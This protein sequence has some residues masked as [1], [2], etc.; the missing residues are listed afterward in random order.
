MSAPVQ[1]TPRPP[2]RAWLAGVGVVAAGVLGA[3]A[4]SVIGRFNSEDP[5][6]FYFSARQRG[7]APL[8]E[9]FGGYVHVIP[10]L[11]A[12]VATAVPVEWAAVAIRGLVL[13]AW[14]FAA[15]VAARVATEAGGPRL[16]M[17]A[18]LAVVACP[19][20]SESV[21][22]VLAA[23]HFPLLAVV[24]LLLARQA[25]TKQG[26]STAAMLVLVVGLSDPITATLLAPAVVLDRA[27]WL[28]TRR[29]R[30]VIA[31]A[32]VALAVQVPTYLDT[33]GGRHERNP[34]LPWSDMS[35]L[36]LAS[37]LLPPAVAAATVLVLRTRRSGAQA[38]LGWRCAWYTLYLSCVSHVLGGIAD[39]YYVAPSIL[40]VVA[41]IAAMR[42]YGGPRR[43]SVRAAGIALGV[44]YLV[45]AVGAFAPRQFLRDGLAW[46]EAVVAA[47]AE[48]SRDGVVTVRID[49]VGGAIDAAPC[50]LFED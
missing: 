5:E 27:A 32:L 28:G 10:R 7:L 35:R 12:W 24:A 14:V 38:R 1:A 18:A 36:W 16:G 21:L 13:A 41:A 40:V 45:L 49:T 9:P 34:L 37:W 30:L 48:C 47:R 19:I 43:A 23:V 6:I 8:L 22:G 39:R 15:V 50:D 4:G 25:E 44:A 11:V 46:R 31:A 2:T 17:A 20:A 26:A 33:A 42:S 29:G 3:R